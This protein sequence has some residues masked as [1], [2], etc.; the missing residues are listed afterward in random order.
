MS[1]TGRSARSIEKTNVAI[2]QVCGCIQAADAGTHESVRFSGMHIDQ[3]EA[4][5]DHAALKVH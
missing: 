4:H 1:G 3:Y 5:A 2:L